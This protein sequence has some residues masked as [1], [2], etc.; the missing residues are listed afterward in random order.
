[1][2]GQV[3]PNPRLQRTPLRAPLSRKPLGRKSMVAATVAAVLL[4]EGCSSRLTHGRAA[5]AIQHSTAFSAAPDRPAP[6]FV[7]V[8]AMLA[9]SENW[10]PEHHENRMYLVGFAYHWPERA[11]AFANGQK[12]IVVYRSPTVLMAN[13][14]LRRGANGWEVD[15]RLTKALTPTWPIL[16]G[17]ASASAAGSR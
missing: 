8:T 10:T 15:E 16:P 14:V 1:M 3:S 12:H 4:A 17:D 7:K 9:G 13:V 6:V 5:R 11:Q 2:V